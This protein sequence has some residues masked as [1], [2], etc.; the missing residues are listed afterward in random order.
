MRF[1]VDECVGPSV[2]R[3]LRENN[4]DATS[5]YEDC[6]GWKDESIIGK[7]YS[8]SIIPQGE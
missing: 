5:V 8:D 1:L 6:R 2:V 4:H 7:A 3:W